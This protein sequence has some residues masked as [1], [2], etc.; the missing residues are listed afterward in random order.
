MLP[1]SVRY[2]SGG[3]RRDEGKIT[4][5]TIS[6]HRSCS[7]NQ[8]ALVAGL[9]VSAV[10][11]R[12]F[13]CSYTFTICSCTFFFLFID[14]FALSFFSWYILSAVQCSCFCKRESN[15]SIDVRLNRIFGQNV[16][17]KRHKQQQQQDNETRHKKGINMHFLRALYDAHAKLDAH[18]SMVHFTHC[19]VPRVP[20]M[21]SAADTSSGGETTECARLVRI[22][23]M[24]SSISEQLDYR[25]YR[26]HRHHRHNPI[27]SMALY[28]ACWHLIVCDT[29]ADVCVIGFE[30]HDSVNNSRKVT[31][32]H[33]VWCLQFGPNDTNAALNEHMWLHLTITNILKPSLHCTLDGIIPAYKRV[34]SLNILAIK[35]N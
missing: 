33:C 6:L 23:R 31:T 4:H 9:A 30:T 26:H 35:F 5:D 8:V 32:W 12:F 10:C 16:M 25:H 18:V 13:L 1:L 7:F 3:N 24:I 28:D 2:F 21:Y 19:T 17:E 22:S 15:A 20:W 11:V 29:L 27:Y 34:Y 14:V